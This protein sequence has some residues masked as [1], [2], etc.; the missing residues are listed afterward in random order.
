MSL[1]TQRN[2]SFFGIFFMKKLM[3]KKKSSKKKI[4]KFTQSQ[5]K[6]GVLH[7][8][9]KCDF[10]FLLLC[11]DDDGANNIRRPT[12]T[13]THTRFQYT[14]KSASSYKNLF[15]CLLFFA[16]VPILFFLCFSLNIFLIY[17]YF[18]ISMRARSTS[19]FYSTYAKIRNL[20]ITY[21]LYTVRFGQL[22]EEMGGAIGCFNLH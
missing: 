11:I 5:L 2:I 20:P 8:N 15:H 13:H 3:T 12:H 7:P 21:Y 16:C 1:L 6:R 14:Y 18:S 17:I 22:N 19:S 10:F 4:Q 9:V